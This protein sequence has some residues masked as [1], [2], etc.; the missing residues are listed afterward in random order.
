M[1]SCN[2]GS[3]VSFFPSD[4]YQ[5]CSVENPLPLIHCLKGISSRF[6]DFSA[7]LLCSNSLILDSIVSQLFSNFILTCSQGQLHR[8]VTPALIQGPSPVTILKFLILLNKGPSIFILHWAQKLYHRS[9]MF[10]SS[11]IQAMR[12]LFKFYSSS[13]LLK[14]YSSS[15]PPPSAGQTWVS[16]VL[17]WGTLCV[18]SHHSLSPFSALTPLVLNHGG[19]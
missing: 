2:L 11:S 4:L 6:D 18:L 3:H 12:V 5:L 13:S 8:H 10:Y 14:F 17:R 19:E 15:S 9:C 7:L 1:S 16:G